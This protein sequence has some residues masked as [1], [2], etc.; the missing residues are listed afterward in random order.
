[1]GQLTPFVAKIFTVEVKTKKK[2][3]N[4][5]RLKYFSQTNLGANTTQ[6][7]LIGKCTNE[8]Q[9]RQVILFNLDTQSCHKH[10]GH[11]ERNLNSVM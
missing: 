1:M 8:L 9:I 7:I 3:C 4:H 11:L 2:R 10:A 6:K 5:I